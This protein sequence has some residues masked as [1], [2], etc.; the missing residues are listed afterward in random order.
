[1]G[2]GRGKGRKGRGELREGRKILY[3]VR[4]IYR[5]MTEKLQKIT[6]KNP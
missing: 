1:M 6:K 4:A 3:D 2:E 5:V